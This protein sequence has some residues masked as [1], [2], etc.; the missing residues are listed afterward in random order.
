MMGP[1]KI[2][3]T[4]LETE[5]GLAEVKPLQLSN[6]EEGETRRDELRG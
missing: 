6:L 1:P 2:L 5:L 3:G 4:H